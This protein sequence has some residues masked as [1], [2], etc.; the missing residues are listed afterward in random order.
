M[1]MTKTQAKEKAREILQS[2]IGC[3]YYKLENENLSDEDVELICQY[4]NALGERA[5]ACKAIN[6]QYIAY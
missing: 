3:A 5:R 2:A 4:I 6:T 1:A